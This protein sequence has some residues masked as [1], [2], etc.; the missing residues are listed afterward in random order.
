VLTG[1]VS[2][3]ADTL[4]VA[5]ELVDVAAGSQLWGDRFHRKI[6]DIF[7]LEEEIA[8]K[9]Y[10]S[11]RVKLSGEEKGRLVKRH[12]EDSEAYQLYLR[13][14][15]H[16][17]KRTPDHVTKGAEYFQKAIDKD[18]SFA[19]AYSGLADC[20][21]ILAIYSIL[22]PRTAFARAKAAAVSAVAF[23]EELAEGHCSLGF[24][25]AFFD[26][27]WHGSHKAFQRS[28]ELNPSYWVS[29][30]WYALVL[31]SVGQFDQAEEQIREGMALE[32]LSPIVMHGAACNSLYAR[33]YDQGIERAMRGLEFDPDYFLLRYWLGIHYSI[34][35]EHVKSVPEL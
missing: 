10:E 12:T 30:Y 4:L 31:S 8:R 21:S 6:S 17:T 27:D 32:P 33:R 19:L 7:A 2:Q 29:R 13:G 18:P 34:L 9:I 16:W 26:L 20:Y 3:R 22:P 28:I 35:G 11:L 15:H 24:I 5:A 1:R 25:R 23:D 14:R